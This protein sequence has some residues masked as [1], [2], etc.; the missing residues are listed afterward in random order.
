MGTWPG[1]RFNFDESLRMTTHEI[2]ANVLMGAFFSEYALSMQ[3][4]TTS[5]SVGGSSNIVT[6]LSVVTIILLVA[7]AILSYLLM[8]KKQ[9]HETDSSSEDREGEHGKFEK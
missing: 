9:L 6:A 2:N 3:G 4:P 8:R 1:S 7:V 5:P